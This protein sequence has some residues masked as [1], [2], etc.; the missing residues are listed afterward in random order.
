L[1][2]ASADKNL[3]QNV[4]SL[5]NQGKTAMIIGTEQSIL[6]VIAVADEV[7]ESS[8]EVIQKLH[9][10]GIKKTIMLTG[11]NKATGQAIGREV[12]VTEIQAELMPEDKL[13][14][15]K[16]LRAEYGNVAMIGDGVNDAPALAA[17][18]VGIAMGGAGTDTAMET[19]DVVLMGDDLS[20]L[21]FTVKLSRKSLNIIKA[22]IAFAIGI[23]AIALL[24]VIPGWLTLW[25]AI[26][27]DMGATLLV[28]LN[29]LRLMRVKE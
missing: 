19:A 12:G 4:T 1:G 27:S 29:S 20:K 2:A 24:L 10:M 14:V 26:M 11:D 21:P 6:A 8:K 3:E 22:N 15:I 5:Q 16:R 9:Q 18:T 28:A 13:N 23:K 7:R 17:S 25:I